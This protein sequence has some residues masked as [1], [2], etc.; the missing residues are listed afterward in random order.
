[1]RALPFRK[2]RD[3]KGN[4]MRVNLLRTGGI[5]LVAG[6]AF[7]AA[8]VPATADTAAGDASAYGAQADVSLLPGVLGPTASVHTDKLAQS[9]AAGPNA[10]TQIDVP[11]QNLVTAKVINSAARLASGEADSDASIVQATFP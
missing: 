3:V 6:A 4:V 1:M 11:L 10:A 7:L 2:R 5:G 9:K 8:A